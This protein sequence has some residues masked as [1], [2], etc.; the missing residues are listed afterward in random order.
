MSRITAVAGMARNRTQFDVNLITRVG[1]VAKS[2]AAPVDVTDAAKD[3]V[4]THSGRSHRSSL[5]RL[6][7]QVDVM[8]RCFVSSG[9]SDSGHAHMR[10]LGWNRFVLTSRS[11]SQPCP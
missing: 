8:E 11:F 10:D 6:T 9:K 7:E 1:L 3:N 5:A 4:A 2:L